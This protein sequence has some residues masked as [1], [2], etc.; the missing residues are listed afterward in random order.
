M[1]GGRL[2]DGPYRRMGVQYCSKD[3]LHFYRSVNWPPLKHT[4]MVSE[5]RTATD[6]VIPRARE[7]A[8]RRVP[9]GSISL[10]S[11]NSPP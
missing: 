3:V 4:A 8:E 2:F 11:T 5:G 9:R 10:E 6:E 7:E 1:E